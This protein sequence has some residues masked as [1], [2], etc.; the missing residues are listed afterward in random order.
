MPSASA[1]PSTRNQWVLV[2]VSNWVFIIG[3]LSLVEILLGVVAV[4]TAREH[5]LVG[6]CDHVRGLEDAAHQ[7]MDSEEVFRLS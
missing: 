4:V 3:L 7:E 5:G 6:H 1:S 2:S